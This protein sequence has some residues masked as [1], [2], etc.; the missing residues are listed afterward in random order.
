MKSNLTKLRDVLFRGNPFTLTDGDIKKSNN[1]KDRPTLVK[2]ICK[3][4]D[5]VSIL[6]SEIVNIKII[7][8][9]TEKCLKK[10]HN[11]IIFIF[12]SNFFKIY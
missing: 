1:E 9:L 5:S 8:R 2:E 10:H 12:L 4:L 6:D 11:L 7:Y 3:R